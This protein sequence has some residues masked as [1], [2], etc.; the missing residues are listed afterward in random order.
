MKQ[1]IKTNVKFLNEDNSINYEKEIY[2]I[3]IFESDNI[4]IGFE[5]E[6]LNN[7]KLEINCK[8]EFEWNGENKNCTS[9]L[10]WFTNVPQIE[11]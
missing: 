1:K 8:T 2:V 3:G 6:D 9:T 7:S 11:L 10:K 5:F 4:F